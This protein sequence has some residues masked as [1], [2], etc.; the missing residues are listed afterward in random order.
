MGKII[1][2]PIRSTLFDMGLGTQFSYTNADFL[3]GPIMSKCGQW[4][5]IY[6]FVQIPMKDQTVGIWNYIAYQ[7]HSFHHC[8][9][10]NSWLAKS[11]NWGI[12]KINSLIIC[13]T[14]EMKKFSLIRCISYNLIRMSESYKIVRNPT[15]GTAK[16]WQKCQKLWRF[17]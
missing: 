10:D 14:L 7:V 16:F 13:I 5:T 15:D 2:V 12:W 4:V 11:T 9:A 1:Y 17:C 6:W 3:P 8:N